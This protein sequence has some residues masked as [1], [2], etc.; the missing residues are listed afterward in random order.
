MKFCQSHWEAVR[1]AI[2]ERGLTPFIAKDSQVAAAQIAKQVQEWRSGKDTFDPLMAAHWNI[3]TN[4]MLTLQRAGVNPLYLMTEDSAAAA[5]RSTCPLCELN[6]VHKQSCKDPSCTLDIE[7]GY[8]WMIARA[9]DDALAQA[10]DYGL[11][12]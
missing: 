4:A 2:D 6:Y 9:A 7:R 8:D 3:A 5:G 11:V 1:T 12:P 10:R